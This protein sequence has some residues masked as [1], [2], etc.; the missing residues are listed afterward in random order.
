MFVSIAARFPGRRDRMLSQ[1]SAQEADSN[2]YAQVIR[3]DRYEV[4]LH[5]GELRKEGQKIRLQPQPFQLL[6]LLLRNAGRIV[7][8]DDIRRDLWPG[9]TFVDFDKGLA[10]A[11]NK[12]RESL[13]DSAEKPK[14]IE[15]LSRRGYRFIG[16]I[17]QPATVL[18]HRSADASDVRLNLDTNSRQLTHRYSVVS[19]VLALLAGAVVLLIYSRAYRATPPKQRAL[20]RVTFDKGLQFDVTWS[21]DG[22]F[23]AYSSDRTGKFDIWVQQISGG[24]PVQVT[25]GPGHNWQPDWSPDGRYIAYRSEDGKGG[26]F[27]VPALGGV[28]LARKI[29]SGG[30]YPRWSP[31]GTRIL[32][33]TNANTGENQFY[34][35]SLDGNE[36]REVLTT[37]IA[38]PLPLRSAAWHPDGKR[39]SVWVWGQGPVPSFWTV[40]VAGGQAVET[41]IDPQI[42]RQL[43]DVSANSDDQMGR[44]ARFS[45]TPSG[46]AIIFERTFRGVRNLWKM[47]VDPKTLKAYAIE[48]L[49]VGSGLDSDF[50]LSADGKRIAFTVEADRVQ[51]WVFPFDAVHGRL[52]GT[53]AA[54]TSP[55]EEAWQPNL[56]RDGRKLVFNALRAGKWG[57]REQSHIDEDTPVMPD[58]SAYG[59]RTPVWSPDGKRLAYIRQK[60]GVDGEQLAIWSADGRTEQPLG[61]PSD[62]DIWVTHW[63]SDGKQILLAQGTSDQYT[64]IIAVPTIVHPPSGTLPRTIAAKSQHYLWQGQFSPDDQWVAFLD[65]SGQFAQFESIVCI[66][67]AT[68]GPWIHATDG[69][70]WVDKPRWA[71]D[72]KTIYFLSRQSGFFDVW[73]IRFDPAKR[74]T[75]GDSFRVTDFGNPSLMIPNDAAVIEFSVTQDKLMLPLT[76]TSGSVWVLDDVDL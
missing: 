13:C 72:G 70:F 41:E 8:R 6:A 45:W 20:S 64:Q 14:F 24:D 15:T 50:A 42:L 3:F 22:R 68:G 32:F 25:K 53:G 52:T 21:P 26:L 31:D 69:K 51:A 12:V 37:T 75:V 40:P 66:T 74:T 29:I 34:V 46:K 23:L 17:A 71:P 67:P 58:D 2:P 9:D 36:P 1:A 76:E 55:A 38:N 62:V 35:A 10:A 5:S 56:S 18:E 73:G 4:D 47:S 28:G 11:V 61:P 30:F 16:E 27:V 59:R 65:Q 7:S 48:R 63:S 49:T 44:D 60:P 43:A 33:Q 57:L 39:I 19:T 54:V